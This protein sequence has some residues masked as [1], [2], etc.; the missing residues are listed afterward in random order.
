[1]PV[2]GTGVQAATVIQSVD[3]STQ[4]T[5]SLNATGSS[6]TA[7]VFA[8]YGVG[9]GS[10]TFGLPNRVY[11]AVGRDKASGSASN[12]MQMSTTI[13]V[14]TGTAAASH[15]FVRRH[16]RQSA[17]DPV[18]HRHQRHFWHVRHAV[19]QRDRNTLRRRRALLARQGRTDARRGWRRAVAVHDDRDS[20]SAS[21]H[22]VRLGGVVQ[23]YGQQLHHP[24]TN[25]GFGGTA[26]GA[27]SG[28]ATPTITSAFTG[29]AQGGTSA[30]IIRPTVP[31]TIV[32]NY[33]IKR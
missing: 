16:V 4:V 14:T 25:L 27:Q 12:I 20:Q 31:P 24:G 22:A 9:D 30:P 11:L 29:V 21:V 7:P 3:N 2:S 19:E 6:T 15:R 26:T 5:L 23:H 32:M 13:N 17:E 18:R 10:T 1:M 28:G 8:P 33:M